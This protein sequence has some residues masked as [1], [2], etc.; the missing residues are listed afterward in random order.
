MK[1]AHQDE[2]LQQ[3]R[4]LL[5]RFLLYSAYGKGM[6]QIDRGECRVSSLGNSG[7]NKTPRYGTNK[8][9]ECGLRPLISRP[10]LSIRLGEKTIVGV[11]LEQIDRGAFY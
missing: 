9:S 5:P 2:V 1:M 10:V 6:R 7:N 11:E 3:D 8:F 4:S